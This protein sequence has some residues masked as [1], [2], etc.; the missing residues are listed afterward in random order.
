MEQDYEIKQYD[1]GTVILYSSRN[2]LN[3]PIIGENAPFSAVKVTQWYDGSTMDNSKADGKIYIKFEEPGPYLGSYFN[4]NLPNFGAT[5]LEKE[6]M[7]QLRALSS[8]EVL[9]LKMGYFK[10]VK[11]NGYYTGGDMGESIVYYISET[12]LPDNG[13][14]ILGVGGLKFE[15]R[16]AGILNLLTFGCKT[17][18]VFDNGDIIQKAI[19]Y[20]APTG[21]KLIFPSGKILTTKGWN[22]SAI[23]QVS[24]ADAFGLEIC[25]SGMSTQIIFTP[26]TQQVLFDFFTITKEIQVNLSGIFA[27]NTNSLGYGLRLGRIGR[28]STF[29]NF[30]LYSFARGHIY[31]SYSYGCTFNNCYIRGCN[32]EALYVDESV[33]GNNVITEFRFRDCYIDNNGRGLNTESSSRYCVNL[34]NCQ[35][36]K[37]ISTV[38]EGNFSFGIVL[39]GY[40]ESIQFIGCRMEETEVA[41]IIPSGHIMSIQAN[42]KNILFL[43][44]EYT[45]RNKGITGDKNYSFLSAMTTDL[46]IFKNTQIIEASD[47]KPTNFLGNTPN[48]GNVFFEDCTFGMSSPIDPDYRK[49]II[50]PR[51]FSKRLKNGYIWENTGNIYFKSTFP[52]TDDDGQ[53]I[54]LIKN[55]KK[56]SSGSTIVGTI[57]DFDLYVRDNIDNTK[58]LY[59]KGTYDGINS[60]IINVINNNGITIQSTDT[61]GS[62]FFSGTSNFTARAITI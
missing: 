14:S 30:R 17:D 22:F 11:L 35:E 51:R 24:N 61:T 50:S 12:T 1:D 26:T 13:G 36:F 5:Y 23:R 37:F 33:L 32:F 28:Y 9:L 39:R 16:Y 60:P 20:I 49:P 8:V 44:G 10:G 34:Y 47:V 15:Y 52:V 31:A 3:I 58:F 38:F 54:N 43:G 40:S 21:G 2:N 59:A 25:G 7:V 53:I 57:G 48:I 55:A 6:T 27:Y 46:V 45:Y 19:D 42:V 18:G 29:S 62:I 56:Q 4:V 41:T